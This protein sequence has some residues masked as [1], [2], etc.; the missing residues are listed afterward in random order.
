MEQGFDWEPTYST[1][2]TEEKLNY[3]NNTSKAP[4]I[5]LS[6]TKWTSDQISNGRIYWPKYFLGTLTTILY[7]L[8]S[9]TIKL[10]A[11]LKKMPGEKKNR[12]VVIRIIS[13]MPGTDIKNFRSLLSVPSRI[14]KALSVHW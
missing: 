12:V 14:S 8:R 3:I 5:E 6:K 9:S 13:N 2:S 1:T 4:V 11:G 10:K 7:C